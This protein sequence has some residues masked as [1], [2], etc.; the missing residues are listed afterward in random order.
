VIFWA[1]GSRAIRCGGVNVDRPRTSH[2]TFGDRGGIGQNHGHPADHVSLLVVRDM[3]IGF[4]SG[5]I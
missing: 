1:R 5:G 3:A 2:E 4:E